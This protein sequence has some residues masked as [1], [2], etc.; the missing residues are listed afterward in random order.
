M[1]AWG[2]GNFENDDAVDWTCDIA[3]SKGVK[4]LITPLRYVASESYYLE[5]PDC[6][7][8]SVSRTGLFRCAPQTGRCASRY[9]YILSEN[10]M[11][12]ST[13]SEIM[14]GTLEFLSNI[15]KSN[16]VPV[17][18]FVAQELTGDETADQMLSAL[19]LAM[20]KQLK[21]DEMVETDDLSEPDAKIYGLTEQGIEMKR[22]FIELAHA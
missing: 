20:L 17:S 9:A 13:G 4:I 6:C 10:G 21:A 22:L 14:A 16:P 1:G 18:S 8:A 19:S 7:Q 2:V 15:K 5:A 12:K 11:G 3:D